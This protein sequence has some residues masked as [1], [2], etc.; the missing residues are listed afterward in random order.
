MY[1]RYTLELYIK[2]SK[3]VLLH[4]QAHIYITPDIQ[5]HDLQLNRTLNH[6]FKV[7]PKILLLCC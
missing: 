6:N 5:S 1:V 2:L 3:H 4:L 7:L